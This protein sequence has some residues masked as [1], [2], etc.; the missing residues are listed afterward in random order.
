MDSLRSLRWLGALLAAFG[1]VLTVLEP[2]GLIVFLTT[3]TSGPFYSWRELLYN[4][5]VNVRNVFQRLGIG[6]ALLALGLFL[7]IWSGRELHRS[8]QRP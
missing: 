4:L 3:W 2:I 7:W 1:V 5:V 6:I 8:E